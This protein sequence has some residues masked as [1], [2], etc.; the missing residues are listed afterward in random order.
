MGKAEIIAI[1]FSS[2]LGTCLR[3]R[4]VPNFSQ[5]LWGEKWLIR[6]QVSA[7]PKIPVLILKIALNF[8]VFLKK[9]QTF[10][11]THLDYQGL[12]R[13]CWMPILVFQAFS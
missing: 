8:E 2:I 5:P 11:F 10:D 1:F 4:N 9:F 3:G 6:Y 13:E 7:S 12:S